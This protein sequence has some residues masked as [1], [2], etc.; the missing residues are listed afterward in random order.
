[1]SFYLK[2]PKH[3]NRHIDSRDEANQLQREG[4]T[5]WPRTKEQKQGIPPAPVATPAP[6]EV[7]IPLPDR[8]PTLT[9]KRGF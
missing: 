1:M 7:Q 8:K 3:G 5:L 4:W 2:H 9:K 6:V